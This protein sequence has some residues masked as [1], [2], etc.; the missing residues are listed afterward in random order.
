MA[1]GKL[2]PIGLLAF[3]LSGCSWNGQ[4]TENFY[5]S[6]NAGAQ[7]QHASICLV[8]AR[9]P[10]PVSYGQS[11][12]YKLSIDGYS[13]A[14]RTELLNHFD[15]VHIA[16]TVEACPKTDLIAVS[17]A[18]III[19]QRENYYR[20]AVS[21]EFRTPDRKVLTQVL[22]ATEGDASPTGDLQ[23][24]TALNGALMGLLAAPTIDAYGKFLTA[25]SEQIF[26]DLL[27]D[28]GRQIQKD[29]FL[30]DVSFL[31]RENVDSDQEQIQLPPKYK[32]YLKATYVIQTPNGLGSGFS[33]DT[34]GTIVTNQHVVGDWAYVIVISDSGEQFKGKVI[35]SDR[36]RDLAIVA[37]PT[38]TSEFFVLGTEK[39]F[40]L[41]DE[42]IAV[43]AP[44][45]LA[46]TVTK[47]IISQVRMLN[48][49]RMIQTDAAINPGNSGGPLI[50]EK[51][52]K[53]VGVNTQAY[54]IDATNNPLQGLNFAVSVDEV[55]NFLKE[56]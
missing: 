44:K 39:E 11:V 50:H 37:I 1:Y 20:G 54:R 47:G 6:Y 17:D 36:R 22:S 51:T 15:E 5:Q 26:T 34:N 25:L 56:R 4:L 28:L 52:G 38:K 46:K 18:R 29:Q 48:T 55:R 16:P 7:R 32:K 13:E 23:T 35:K 41:G 49:V 14:L 21:L 53:L 8:K 45:R 42:V 43:G 30:S 2:V 24:K 3:F 19:N 27:T 10:K 9:P 40:A 31:K 12:D 33:V